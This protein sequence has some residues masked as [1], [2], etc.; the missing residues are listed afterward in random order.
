MEEEKHSR[1]LIW[2]GFDKLKGNWNRALSITLATDTG[3][4][5]ETL[6]CQYDESSQVVCG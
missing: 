4:T 2:N 1:L 5:E 3:A 6:W